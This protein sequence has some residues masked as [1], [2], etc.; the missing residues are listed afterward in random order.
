MRNEKET[1]ESFVTKRLYIIGRWNDKTNKCEY[2]RDT[3]SWGNYEFSDNIDIYKDKIKV[4]KEP[5]LPYHFLEG[6]EPVLR[7]SPIFFTKAFVRTRYYKD[8][9][10]EWRESISSIKFCNANHWQK[11]ESLMNN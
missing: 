6:I 11:L 3:D 4:N 9:W 2:L 10:G 1:C 8:R 7:G 5:H